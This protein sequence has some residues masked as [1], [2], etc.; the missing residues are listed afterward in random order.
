MSSRPLPHGKRMQ[1]WPLRLGGLPCT[2][3]EQAVFLRPG[4]QKVPG[5]LLTVSSSEVAL[6]AGEMTGCR[7]RRHPCP[8]PSGSRLPPRRHPGVLRGWLR[9]V[10][11]Q[12]TRGGSAGLPGVAH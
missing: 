5:I 12:L 1:S 3:T 4:V 9:T 7:V 10:A 8:W 6:Q 11:P 2:P